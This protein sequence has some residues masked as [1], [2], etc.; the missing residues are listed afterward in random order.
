MERAGGRAGCVLPVAGY[1]WDEWTGSCVWPAVPER[2]R[3]KECVCW[4]KNNSHFRACLAREIFDHLVQNHKYILNIG[5]I[6][7]PG[8]SAYKLALLEKLLE[9]QILTNRS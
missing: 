5:Q 9:G 8:R 4:Y 3:K 7:I 1:L 6:S 2:R